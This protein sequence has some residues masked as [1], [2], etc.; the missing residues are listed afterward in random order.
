MILDILLKPTQLKREIE[1]MRNE[2]EALRAFA[3]SKTSVI[4]LA[5]GHGQGVSRSLENALIKVADLDAEIKAK[6]EELDASETVL[7]KLLEKLDDGIYKRI[8]IHKYLL[9]E[10]WPIISSS[11]HV[12]E[13]QCHYLHD[14]ALQKL[15]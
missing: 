11:I 5:P 1:S 6:T 9:N 12:S 8:L 14:E 2:Q 15:S 7:M 4:S 13:R 10:N 3:E